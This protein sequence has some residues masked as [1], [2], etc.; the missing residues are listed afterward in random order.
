MV[1]MSAVGVAEVDSDVGVGV[2]VAEVDSDVGVGVGV[3]VGVRVVAFD[4]EVDFGLES[5]T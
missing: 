5:T 2:G 1:I 3:G 4:E